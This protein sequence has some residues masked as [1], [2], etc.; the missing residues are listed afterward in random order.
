MYI[1]SISKCTDSVIKN[2]VMS[3]HINFMK[4]IGM[5]FFSFIHEHFIFVKNRF[6]DKFILEHFK[7]ISINMPDPELSY[8]LRY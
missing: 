6:I 5:F 7:I 2:L 1:E 8:S 3:I 4:K